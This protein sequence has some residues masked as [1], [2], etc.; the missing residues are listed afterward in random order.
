M[1]LPQV[2]SWVSN[3]VW[4]D[5]IF[6]NFVHDSLVSNKRFFFY[7]PLEPMV[8]E[9]NG[10]KWTIDRPVNYKNA[11]QIQLGIFFQAAG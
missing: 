2:S 5:Q 6:I 10:E 3:T 4:D 1:D 11:I 7:Q 8:S 9:A